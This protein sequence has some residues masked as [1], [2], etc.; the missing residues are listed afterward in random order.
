M[1]QIKNAMSHYEYITAVLCNEM[2]V[3]SSPG[4]KDIYRKIQGY[5]DEKSEAGLK[6]IRAKLEEDSLDDALL[7]DSDYFRFLYN[8][9]QRNSFRD[10]IMN[11]ISLITVSCENINGHNKE[12]LKKIMK[13]VS[14]ILK[15]SLRKGDVYSFWNETQILI[16]LHSVR[17][18]SLEEIEIRIR[19]SFRNI[20]KINNCNISIEFSPLKSKQNITKKPWE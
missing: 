17:E 8:I 2:G 13:A 6:S 18:D 5:Y 10:E 7:C 20:A 14:S 11:F 1:G 9:G 12:E 16:M 15:K 3:K 19:E 4:L